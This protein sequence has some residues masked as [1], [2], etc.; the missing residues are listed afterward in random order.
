VDDV[1]KLVRILREGDI[2]I[3]LA[4][5]N[6]MIDNGYRVPSCHTEK[7]NRADDGGY[8]VVKYMHGSDME[9]CHMEDLYKM[10]DK[11]IVYELSIYLFY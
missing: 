6:M 10:I 4:M 7:N 2:S 8:R 1:V 9:G 3:D 11:S 5:V